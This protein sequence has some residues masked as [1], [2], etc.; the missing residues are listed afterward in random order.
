MGVGGQRQSPAALGPGDTCNHCTVGQMGP[1]AGLEGCG[2]SR[3]RRD[4]ISGP[5]SP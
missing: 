1:M 3:P 5:S 4:S 2:K